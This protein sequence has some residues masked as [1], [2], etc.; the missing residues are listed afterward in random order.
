MEAETK[1]KFDSIDKIIYILIAIIMIGIPFLKALSYVPYL[2]NINEV[3]FKRA[4]V[5]FIWISIIFSFLVYLYSL[6]SN[7]RKLN[8]IDYLFFILGYLGVIS[9][10]S[11]IDLNKS[12]FGEPN[13]YEGL[14][15]LFGYYLVALNA[16]NIRSDHIKK[17]ILNIFIILGV[18]QSIMGI[19]QSLTAV[20]FVKRFPSAP[21]M[22][23]GL[24]SNPNFYGSYIGMLLGISCILFIKKINIKNILLVILFSINLYLCGSLG[25]LLAF[26]ITFVF[27]SILYRKSYKKLICLFIIISLSLFISDK[28]LIY[29]Q[30][31]VLNNK[32]E[33]KNYI[34]GDIKKNYDI[35]KSDNIKSLGTGRLNVWIN[36]IP[37][38]KKYWLTGC[39]IDNFRDAYPQKGYVSFDKAH[40]VYIQIGVTNGVIALIVYLSICLIA[41]LKSIKNRNFLSMCFF[42]SFVFYSIQAFSNISVIDVAPYFYL[43][44]GLLISC[45]SK[46]KQP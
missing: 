20:S 8:Y 6:I 39:G 46:I 24:C 29:V 45:N 7:K 35:L 15:T 44:L 3:L 10:I 30:S 40:N 33:T 19:L 41:F 42:I 22:A 43:I 12:I 34:K 9:T 2:T 37:L 25:P 5:Y 1:E 31:N 13:R 28:S 27:L 11:A 38:L 4:R 16:K 14:L 18:F 23:F 21:Y 36:S 32:I 17:K 26:I